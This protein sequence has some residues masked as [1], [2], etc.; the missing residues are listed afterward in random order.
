MIPV[1]DSVLLSMCILYNQWTRI[2]IHLI[3]SL[4]VRDSV[5]IYME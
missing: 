3:V 1:N 4:A 5:L 2:I